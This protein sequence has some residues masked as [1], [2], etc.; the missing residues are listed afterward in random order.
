MPLG[1]E[2]GSEGV[3]HTKRM[4]TGTIDSENVGVHLLVFAIT[5][6]DVDQF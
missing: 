1:R 5:K 3:V 6:S 2:G 4:K